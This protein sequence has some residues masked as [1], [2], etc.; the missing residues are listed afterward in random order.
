MYNEYK[1]IYWYSGL[2][3]Q[4]QHFQS[5]D[6]HHSYMLA[7]HRS[8]A[9]PWNFGYYECKINH[10]AL[11]ESILK[12]DQL[13][14]ILPSGYYLEYPGNCTIPQRHLF[15]SKITDGNPV[16]FWIALRRFD[17]RFSNVSDSTD[18]V[19]NTRWVSTA[20][21]QT[22]RDVYHNGPETGITRISYNIHIITDDEKDHMLDCEL[23]PLTRLIYETNGII[24]DPNFTPPSLTISHSEVLKR[25]ITDIY[26]SLCSCTHKLDECKH[27][28]LNSVSFRKNGNI[29]RLL[30]LCIFN[31]TLPLLESWQQERLVHPWY[32]F[33][34]L[35]QLAGELS[36]FDKTSPSL[37]TDKKQHCVIKYDHYDLFACFSSIKDHL[38]NLLAKLSLD[39]NISVPLQ[40]VSSGIFSGDIVNDDSVRCGSAYIMLKS[41]SFTQRNKLLIHTPDM[42]IASVGDI[43]TI[44]Q[45][46]LPGIPMQ[47]IEF[48]PGGLP[49]RMDTLWLKIDTDHSIWENIQKQKN[50]AFY[51]V[52][53]PDDLYIELVIVALSS[54]SIAYKNKM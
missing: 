21:E 17:P 42:K 45:H 14:A 41:E 24:V 29:V 25:T 13:K 18:K 50:I 15:G 23:L 48:A 19:G 32:F 53:S 35:C 26:S 38:S 1:Q 20:E 39:E 47:L 27:T 54:D 52:A 49:E 22:M 36:S 8:I 33:N 3:L 46:A 40:K 9:Q 43:N 5:V 37:T 31:R 28:E 12:I 44:I 30:M 7:Q 34:L 11:K 2:Y 4:P 6:L 10:N 51:W 16:K